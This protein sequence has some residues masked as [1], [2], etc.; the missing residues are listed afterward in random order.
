MS[1]AAID[2]QIASVSNAWF[3]YFFNSDPLPTLARVH[4]PVLALNGTL[5][6][7]VP[8]KDNL[9]A[10]RTALAH[11]KGVVTVEMPG[12]NHLFQPATTGS[13]AEYGTTETTMA[14]EALKTIGDWV[15]GQTGR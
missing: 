7:Q 13:V 2:A 11:D 10:I 4:V 14:P 3:H 6:L 5:D 8:L 15:V 1:P 9:P 12:L